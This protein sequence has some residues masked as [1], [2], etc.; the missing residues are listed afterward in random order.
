LHYARWAKYGAAHPEILT[1]DDLE[2]MTRSGK[3]FAR[4][5]DSSSEG[6]LDRIDTDLLK[7]RHPV[8]V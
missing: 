2:D 7:L 5:F 1:Q 8:R 3:F 6:L 4:K